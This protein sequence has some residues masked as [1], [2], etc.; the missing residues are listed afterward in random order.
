MVCFQRSGPSAGGPTESPIYYKGVLRSGSS[1]IYFSSIQCKMGVTRTRMQTHILTR[2]VLSNMTRRQFNLH[3]MFV[4]PC[5]NTQAR[6]TYIQ[7]IF[8]VKE[9]QN[10]RVVCFQRA[11]PSAGGPTDIPIYYKGV[12]RSGSSTIFL[13]SRDVHQ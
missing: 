4:Q 1:T 3:T 12:L 6:R 9:R 10:V 8:P 5:S 11:G 7:I 2:H 13:F